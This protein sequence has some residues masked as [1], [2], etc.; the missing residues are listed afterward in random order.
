M[1]KLRARLRWTGMIVMYH[2]KV[3][4]ITINISTGECR[5]GN[6]SM[7]KLMMCVYPYESDNLP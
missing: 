6:T 5:V 4:F 3:K 1:L 2:A 7:S